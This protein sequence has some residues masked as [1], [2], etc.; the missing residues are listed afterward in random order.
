[1]DVNLAM[2]SNSCFAPRNHLM[3]EGETK[4]WRE[5]DQQIERFDYKKID[6]KPNC[7]R[8]GES[9]HKFK[10]DGGHFFKRFNKFKGRGKKSF[11]N[12]NQW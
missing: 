8:A 1:M 3:S 4:F 10:S 9:T 11:V 6:L 12:Y 5:M 2:D 7:Y